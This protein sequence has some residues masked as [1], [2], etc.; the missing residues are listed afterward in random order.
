MANVTEISPPDA[1]ETVESSPESSAPPTSAPPKPANRGGRPPKSSQ[2]PPEG[3]QPQFF[4][5]V[6]AAAKEDWGQR[7]Y[8]YVYVS[9][10][11]LNAKTFGDTKYLLKSSTPILDLEVLKQDYG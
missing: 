6:A 7:A 10:P 5:R 4:D 11:V 2:R 8:M 9:E 1:A 3:R